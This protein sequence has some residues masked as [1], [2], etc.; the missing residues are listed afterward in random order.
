MP[1]SRTTRALTAAERRLLFARISRQ[2][3]IRRRAFLRSLSVSLIGST[4]LCVL[5]LLAST[6]SRVLIVMFWLALAIC[7]AF[8]IGL[9]ARRAAARGIRRL[10]SAVRA[11][12]ADAVRISSSQCLQFQEVEDEGAC[13]AFETAENEAVFVVG[14]DF[15]PSA[16]FPS[17]DFSLIE[18]LSEDGGVV[19]L[20]IQNDGAKLEPI[21]VIPAS[22]KSSL[23]IPEHLGVV[24]SSLA[25][26]E[27][28]LAA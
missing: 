2:R 25:E 13:W 3:A 26:L 7:M 10:E 23:R 1:M 19:D 6:D 20:I 28:A 27:E 22:K 18:I 8:W 11:D 4:V 21:R 12:R 14:Q 16:R 15:Y 5:T 9:E 24:R 17:T